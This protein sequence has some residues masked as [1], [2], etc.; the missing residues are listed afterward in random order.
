MDW[1]I[2][3]ILADWDFEPGGAIVR[4]FIGKD[5]VEKIQMRIDLGILQMNADGR[6]DGKLPYGKPSYFDHLRDKLEDFEE[7]HNGDDDGFQLESKECHKLQ[8]EAIQYHHRYIC[9]FQLEDYANVVR[10]TERN[11]D[12]ISFVV[13]YCPSEENIWSL[14]QLTP[15]LLMMRT[16]ST[17][18]QY[19]ALGNH[20]KAITNVEEGLEQLRAFYDSVSRPDLAEDSSELQALETWLE[21]LKDQRPLSKREKLEIELNEAIRQENFEKAAKVRD[22]IKNLES[23]SN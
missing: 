7:K 10:D 18:A 15:Q 13:Q 21:E 14:R 17:A 11:L 1:D 22:E 5:G 8:Q 3:H 6:P 9:Y 23:S 20:S 12:A 2:S 16:R 4:R 19:L